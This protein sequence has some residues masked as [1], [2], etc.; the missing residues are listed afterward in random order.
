MLPGRPDWCVSFGANRLMECGTGRAEAGV[1]ARETDIGRTS[2]LA[3][4]TT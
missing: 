1:W 3:C 4:A 2:V